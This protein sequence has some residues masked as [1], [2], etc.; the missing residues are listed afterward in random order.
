M[1]SMTPPVNVS[2]QRGKRLSRWFWFNFVFALMPLMLAILIRI[3]SSKLSF[4]DIASSSE[5]LFF[6]LMLS[7][8]SIGDA[9][10]NSK[11]DK[12]HVRFT[13]MWCALLF[14]AIISSV[15][16]GCLLLDTILNLQ[17]AV[18]R[19]K[20]FYLSVLLALASFGISFSTQLWIAKVEE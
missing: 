12:N 19:S 10:E 7:A 8:T 17:L 20:L 16:Y 1:S 2:S 3:L 6:S 9:I 5:V 18:F 13:N 11:L 14:V 4:Q 15:L